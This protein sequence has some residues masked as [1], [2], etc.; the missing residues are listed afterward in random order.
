MEITRITKKIDPLGRILIPVRMREELNFEVSKT[1]LEIKVEGENIILSKTE[2]SCIFCK[3]SKNLI[4]YR[5]KNICA[6]CLE[7]LIKYK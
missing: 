6:T 1:E 3:E 5:N 7:D 2:K 4:P